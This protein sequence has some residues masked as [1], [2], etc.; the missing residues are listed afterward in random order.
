[1]KDLCKKYLDNLA[2]CH[3]LDRK[4]LF[5]SVKEADP[6]LKQIRDNAQRYY[7]LRVENDS[8][9]DKIVHSR[10][11]EDLTQADV[12]ELL[13]FAEKLFAYVHQNDVGTAYR[14]HQLVL[15][16]A[17][18]NGNT[19]L[20]IRQF[21]RLG[22]CLYYLNPL[23]GELSV[24]PFGHQIT[25]YFSRGAAY[26]SR[27]DEFDNLTTRD[28][29]LRCATNLCIA[30][31]EISGAHN[32]C[33]PFDTMST[34]PN[35]KKFFDQMME[36]YTDPHYHELSPEFN[37]ERA[38]YNLHF[39]RSAYFMDL[40]EHH[41]SEVLND[42]LESAEYLYNHQ[43]QLQNF[44]NS[45]KEARLEHIYATCR[46]KAGLITTTEL[47]ETTLF[48]IESAAPNDFSANGITVNLQLPLYLEQI[49]LSMP[50]EQ[51]SV[52]KER[53]NRVFANMNDYLLRA[54][55]NEYRNVVTRTITEAIRSRA[56]HGLPLHTGLFDYLLFCHPPTYIHVHS[57]ATLSRILLLRLLD[58]APEKLIGLY[59]ISSVDE[60]RAK[61][62]ELVERIYTCSLYHDVGKIALLDYIGIYSRKLLDE[63][64]T[65]IQLHTNIGSAL[66]RQLDAKEL[67]EVALHHHRFYDGSRGYPQNCP[68]CPAEYRAIVDIVSVSDALEA[69]TDN[70]G[71]CYSNAKDFP[72]IINELRSERGTRYSPDVVALFDD[73]EFCRTLE[74][75]L[76]ADRNRAYVEIY[77]KSDLLSAQISQLHLHQE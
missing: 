37:W 11:A 66:L 32:P 76:T 24:N 14:I 67:S 49:Y 62:D 40:Q 47:L 64:F 15:R 51:R 25:E 9:L 44:K 52:Y 4:N 58:T 6:L 7:Q 70:V 18:L 56:Q 45:T 46:H 50:A 75:E 63:E 23:L 1:M 10:R 31:D 54:P 5:P 36:I 77:G 48:L 55:H 38:I 59:G 43:E 21:Y 53:I 12:D 30:H 33:T 28:Y 29:I 42:I 69:A 19:D 8:L 26:I 68:P 74:Q 73:E 61:R 57:A 65:A 35:F 71:R 72:T 2:E 16:Y 39:N 17:E 13:A 34:Y 22:V 27:L 20:M 60:L 41:S 3:V